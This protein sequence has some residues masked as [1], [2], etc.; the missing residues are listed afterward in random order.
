MTRVGQIL[1]FLNLVF[2][3]VVGGFAV[4]DYT[5]RTHWHKS[6]E[7]L[8]K[9]YVTLQQANALW[10]TEAEQERAKNETIA[11]ALHT[12]N[13]DLKIS[14][15]DNKD[16]QTN[17]VSK[18][19]AALDSLTDRNTKLEDGTKRLIKEIA[20]QKVLVAEKSATEK[21]AE[22]TTASRQ[23]DAMQLRKNLEDQTN[24]NFKLTR[25]INDAT[26]K[27]V[28]AEIRART[29][30]DYNRRLLSRVTELEKL[31]S[32][33]FAGRP[34][35]PPQ[36]V[37]GLVRRAEGSLVTIS[38]GSDNGLARGQM[39]EVF[40]LGANARYVGKIRIETVTPTQAVGQV[41]GRM[42]TPIQVGDHVASRII[43]SP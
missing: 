24:E 38:L 31:K 43:D 1:L 11:K 5:A 35:A 33:G 39:L 8:K 22:V 14:A 30:E 10:K 4:V 19:L 23:V 3:L 41:V 25:K 27:M 26:D 40:R 18:T 12:N 28:Q 13:V 2:S 42:N 16:D 37:E 15:K 32:A 17:A 21:A 20:D 9:D 29:M 6:F 7:T 34:N 36:D